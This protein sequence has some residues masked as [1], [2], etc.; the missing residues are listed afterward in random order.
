MCAQAQW[1][2]AGWDGGAQLQQRVPLGSS[3]SPGLS[4]APPLQEET[5]R[6]ALSPER[7]GCSRRPSG[8]REAWLGP[9][10]AAR[11]A[12]RPLSPGRTLVREGVSRRQAAGVR[13]GTELRESFSSTPNLP[14]GLSCWY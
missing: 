3:P 10:G 9:E 14:H 5:P 13:D 6:A 7:G 2:P 12:L 11:A 4:P 1:C 8:D